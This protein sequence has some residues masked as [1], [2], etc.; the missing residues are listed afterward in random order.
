MKTEQ[1]KKDEY[2]TIAWGLFFIWWGITE[3]FQSLPSG[4]GAIGIGLILL[5]MNAARARSGIPTS[6]F[7][8]TLGILALIFG[9]LELVGPVLSLPYEIPTFA[10]LL[11]VLGGIVL[12]HGLSVMK[13]N[14]MEG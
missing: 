8:S 1:S 10:I 3:V 12:S 4:T 6:S 14:K 2:E 5:G 11:M 13:N 9:G 7:S